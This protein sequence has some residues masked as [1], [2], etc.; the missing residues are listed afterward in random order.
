M[1]AKFALHAVDGFSAKGP[2]IWSAASTRRARSFGARRILIVV[3]FA[4]VA[5]FGFE[6]CVPMCL[7]AMTTIC[8]KFPRLM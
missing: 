8:G 1:H 5:D 2:Y 4:P 6:E 3:S 7:I